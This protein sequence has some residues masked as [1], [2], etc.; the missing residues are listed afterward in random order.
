MQQWLWL[1]LTQMRNGGN[2]VS[3]EEAFDLLDIITISSL[4]LQ[5]I[6]HN[7]TARQ[8]TNDD[9]MQEL[10]S[11]DRKYLDK[12]IENQNEILSILSQINEDMSAK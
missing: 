11:Q 5:I 3:E 7:K 10:Q 6:D 12:I 8:L 1:C 2:S 4:I 9:L